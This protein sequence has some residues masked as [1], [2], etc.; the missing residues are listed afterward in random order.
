LLSIPAGSFLMGYE[1]P[2]ANPGDEEGPVRSV[3][4]AE[5]QIAETTVTNSEFAAFARATGYVTEAE[6]WGWS[7][8]FQ[9]LVS[10]WSSVTGRV[11]AAQWWCAVQGA[12]WRTPGGPHSVA[13]DDHPVVHVSSHDAEAYCAWVGARLPTEQEWE[14]AA[15]G[16]LEQAVYPWGDELGQRCNIWQGVFPTRHTGEVG[17]RPARAYEP[18]GFGLYQCVGNVWE[19]TASEWGDGRVRRGGSYLC[20]ASYC[21]RYRVAARDRSSPGDSTG[22]IG[23]RIA[24]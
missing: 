24:L 5:F 1:G 21:N 3:A 8:V 14:R 12:T 7:F 9:D 23:F 10:D 13:A 16:G 19:W 6:R 15:R 2:L 11:Q 17:T 18:N 4:L 22:N 20:H